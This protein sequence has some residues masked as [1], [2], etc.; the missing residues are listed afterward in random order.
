ML[1]LKNIHVVKFSRLEGN[2][3]K[4]QKIFCL[5]NFPI[6][7]TQFLGK[8]VHTYVCAHASIHQVIYSH[9]HKTRNTPEQLPL[10][11]NLGGLQ[12]AGSYNLYKH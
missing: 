1:C 8:L 9:E 7:G 6:H 4:Q 5:E 2:P 12:A 11:I 10:L 3:R